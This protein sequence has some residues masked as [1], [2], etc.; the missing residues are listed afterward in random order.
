MKLYTLLA[1]DVV[2]AITSRAH[3]VGMTV[4]GHVPRAL[5]ADQGVERGAVP[6]EERVAACGLAG[7]NAVDEV[8][9]RAGLL[10]R[11]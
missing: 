3:A 2:S 5:T 1:P 9:Q 8:A 11:T 10:A 4:T 7:D 6:S